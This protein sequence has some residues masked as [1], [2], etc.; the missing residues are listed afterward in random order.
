VLLTAPN[1]KDTNALIRILKSPG[2]VVEG[3][4]EISPNPNSQ[5]APRLGESHLRLNGY[6]YGDQAFVRKRKVKG[7]AST[8]HPGPLALQLILL[9]P[10]GLGVTVSVCTFLKVDGN[11]VKKNHNAFVETTIFNL[12]GR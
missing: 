6:G 10:L 2:L 1:S 8:L 9:I 11:E 12:S 7:L 5:Q 3:G 4:S